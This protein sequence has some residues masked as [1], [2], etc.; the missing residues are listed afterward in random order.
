M[1]DADAYI[2]GQGYIGTLG[3]DAPDVIAA[4]SDKAEQLR[5]QQ[6][7]VCGRFETGWIDSSECCRIIAKAAGLPEPHGWFDSDQVKQIFGKANWPNFDGLERGAEPWDSS[8]YSRHVV[9]KAFVDLCVE[10]N[11]EIHFG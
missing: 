11:L 7:I 6:I 10:Y 3:V 2:P 9:A 4:F 1:V 8:E 5:Q